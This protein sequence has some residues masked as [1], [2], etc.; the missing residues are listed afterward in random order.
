MSVSAPSGAD[1]GVE[2]AAEVGEGAGQVEAV[3][4][5]EVE[6]VRRDLAAG[7]G[8]RQMESA[9]LRPGL[10][11][12]REHGVPV[13]GGGD[14][15]AQGVGP[16]L[17]LLDVPASGLPA[18]GAQRGVD[19]DGEAGGPGAVGVHV[20]LRSSRSWVGAGVGGGAACGSFGG[21]GGVSRRSP[22]STMRT[23]KWAL[24]AAQARQG[25]A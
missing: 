16:D 3:Q 1:L 17:G 23:P 10:D 7:A 22:G 19:G 20:P 18:G 15:V 6:A 24:R 4:R 2:G 11:R 9:E 21:W 25:A 14:V 8:G 5:V 12:G 13:S